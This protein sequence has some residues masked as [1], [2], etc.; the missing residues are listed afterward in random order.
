MKRCSA[1]LE[2]DACHDEHNSHDQDSVAHRASLDHFS[3]PHD[4][5][6]PVDPYTIDMP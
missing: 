5:Q 3:Y 2:A 1:Q 6:E 4:I